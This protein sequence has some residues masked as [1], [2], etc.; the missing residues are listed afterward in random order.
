MRETRRDI[1][2]KVTERKNVIELIKWLKRS[3]VGDR[4]KFIIEHRKY[5][6]HYS[7]QSKKDYSKYLSVAGNI[8]A[9]KRT[10]VANTSASDT[11]GSR[12]ALSCISFEIEMLRRWAIL[13]LRWNRHPLKYM[14]YHIAGHKIYPVVRFTR[15]FATDK[16][17]RI[18]AQFFDT[19]NYLD[20]H[21]VYCW[22]CYC[23]KKRV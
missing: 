21:V 9:Y 5:R 23:V 19:R 17:L 13:C 2:C 1:H 11:K 4:R 6:L 8:I 16:R 12:R 22:R 7:T 18:T 10:T 20:I 14:R 3:N 15:Q